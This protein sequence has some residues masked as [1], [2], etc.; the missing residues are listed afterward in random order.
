MRKHS[1]FLPP[2]ALSSSS[3][4]LI[5]AK[6]SQESSR[7]LSLS[8]A[9]LRGAADLKIDSLFNPKKDAKNAPP[10]NAAFAGKS[11]RAE[12]TGYMPKR[13]DFDVEFDND[14]ELL[15]AEMEFNGTQKLSSLD[16]DS[17]AETEM[18]YRILDIYNLRLK[19]RERR[20]NFV[21]DRDMLNLKRLMVLDK[22][23]SKE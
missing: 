15:L 7:S 17:K 23:Q 18:K 6:Q 12:I 13:R 5:W 20:K 4:S 16:S 21:I 1:G 11:N 9:K 3:K 19:E 10:C 2:K 22:T 8:P 14:A